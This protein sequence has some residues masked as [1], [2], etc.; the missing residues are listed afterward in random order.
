MYFL[1]CNAI[2]R[3]KDFV[4]ALSF[5]LI[6]CLVVFIEDLPIAALDYI[7][8]VCSATVTDLEVV[9]IEYFMEL[10]WLWE[11]LIN[12]AKE[13]FSDVCSDILTI[14]D[15]ACLTKNIIYEATLTT[16]S[17]NAKTCIGM[18]EH[19][20]KTRFNNHKLSFKDRKHSHDTELSKH[21]E[22]N[23]RI[24]KRASAY[25]GKPSRCNLCLAE[26]LCILTA[27]NASLLNKRFELVTEC[28]HEDKFFM[29]T[30]Q[31]KR[32]SNH[33]WIWN[34]YNWYKM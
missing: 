11:M 22:I 15:S 30:N 23:W 12:Q 5:L 7:S 1:H 25:K 17:G 18:T 9:S 24:I 33:S 3:A 10:V 6:G 20:F 34:V 32:P 8:H 4:S 14:L 19:E 2:K 21:S 16:T 29:A 27:Q 26:K 31:K 13:W 28:R